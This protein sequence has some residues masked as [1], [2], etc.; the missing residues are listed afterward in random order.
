MAPRS[1]VTHGRL[2]AP[3]VKIDAAELH[4]TRPSVSTAAEA[5]FDELV[6]F[7]FRATL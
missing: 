3:D 5:W 1:T 4:D 2:S 6:T 7:L